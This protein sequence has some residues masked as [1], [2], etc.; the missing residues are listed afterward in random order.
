MYSFSSTLPIGYL[1][2]C[3]VRRKK[4]KILRKYLEKGEENLGY[5]DALLGFDG[6]EYFFTS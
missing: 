2:R 3:Q 5:C 6:S 1:G 4:D